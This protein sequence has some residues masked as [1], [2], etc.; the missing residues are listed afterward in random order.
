MPYFVYIMASERN[1]TI[2][3]GVTN[4]LVRR[5]FEHK[6]GLL[7]GFTKDYDVKTLVY[8]ESYDDVRIAI[9]REK[10]LK[11]WKRDWKI[12]LIEGQ[13]PEW[14]DLSDSLLG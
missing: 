9:Q 10:N 5:V 1:G 8:Y 4:N 7:P 6:Q 12:A 3:T 13:N 14:H 11:H 2:Y